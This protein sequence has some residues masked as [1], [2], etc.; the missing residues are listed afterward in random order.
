MSGGGDEP[1]ESGESLEG[2]LES[3]RGTPHQ[4]RDLA[5]DGSDLIAAGLSPGPE[6]GRTLEE[7][8]SRVVDDPSLNTRERLLAEVARAR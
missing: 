3:E 4:L 1:A 7:L 5:I 6:L 8:L 2:M